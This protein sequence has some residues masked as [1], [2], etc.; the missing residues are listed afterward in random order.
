MLTTGLTAE[1]IFKSVGMIQ[2]GSY[3]ESKILKHCL[4]WRAYD[5]IC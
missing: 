5:D 4:T 2:D 1:S 3:S